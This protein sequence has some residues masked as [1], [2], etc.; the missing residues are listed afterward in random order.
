MQSRCIQP[1]QLTQSLNLY[2]SAMVVQAGRGALARPADV[3]GTLDPGGLTSH[4]SLLLGAVRKV[5]GRAYAHAGVTSEVS[6]GALELGGSPPPSLLILEGA[7][8]LQPS[9]PTKPTHRL[10]QT[11]IQQHEWGCTHA[12]KV[13]MVILEALG[14]GRLYPPSLLRAAQPLEPTHPTHAIPQAVQQHN[15]N[16]SQDCVDGASKA[17]IENLGVGRVHPLALPSIERHNNGAAI[18]HI[19]FMGRCDGEMTSIDLVHVLRRV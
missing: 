5:A 17:V 19:Q 13:F 2:N 9:L 18:Q 8:Q 1:F 6:T 10:V 14:D 12:V 16:A 15:S 11:S 3:I 7:R 4:P